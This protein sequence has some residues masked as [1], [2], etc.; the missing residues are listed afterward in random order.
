MEIRAREEA[1]VAGAVSLA[2]VRPLLAVALALERDTFA[3]RDRPELSIVAASLPAA[4]RRL[5]VL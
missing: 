3:A 2:E 5:A 4:E 1:V